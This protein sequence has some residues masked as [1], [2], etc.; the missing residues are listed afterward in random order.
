MSAPATFTAYIEHV[1]QQLTRAVEVN[2]AAITTAADWI[3]TAIEAGR[4]LHVFGASHAG[5][6]AQDLFFRAGGLVPVQPILPAG[7]MLNERPVQRT[8]RLE[9]LPGFA[10]TFMDDLH[11]DRADVLLVISVS[12]RNPVAV[13][14]CQLAQRA[15]ARVIALTSV[16]YSS[17]VQA[18]VGSLRLYEAADLCLDLPAVHGDAVLQVTADGPAVGPT[19]TA[20]GSAILHGLSCEV[21]ALLCRRGMSPPVF[22]SANLDDSDARNNALLA[23]YA[24]RI[25][26]TH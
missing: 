20:V 10:A 25:T 13:E 7:L 8:S 15:G 14:A 1:Q 22:A 24:D 16:A 18:R 5:L 9:R 11:L 2:L 4:P 17:R 12:G 23:T 21:A 6:L 19:S 3:A 26:Y